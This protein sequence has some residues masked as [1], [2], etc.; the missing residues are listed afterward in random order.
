MEKRSNAPIYIILL[1]I[2]SLSALA[3]YRSQIYIQRLNDVQTIG[4]SENIQK[5]LSDSESELMYLK[6][7]K[8][9]INYFHVGHNDHRCQ[10]IIQ[11][12]KKFAISFTY[13]MPDGEYLLTLHDGIHHSL[14]IPIL[15]FASTKDLVE[16]NKVVLIPDWDAILGYSYTFKHID[17][18]LAKYPWHKK[19]AKVFWRGSPT[20][21]GPE[22]ND[23]N[24]TDR[25]RFLN[26]AKDLPFVDAAFNTYATQMNPEFQAKVAAIHKLKPYVRPEDSII[27]KYLIDIDGNSCSYARMAWILY[28]NSVLFKHMS[29]KVQ[30]YYS[31]MQPYVHYIPIANDFSN[32]QSQFT[33]AESHQIEVEAIALNGRKLAMKVFSRNGILKAAAQGFQR[34]QQ[35]LSKRNI[36]ATREHY[37]T[38]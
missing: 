28:S 14:E 13:D 9:T 34:Y 38:T 11:L 29:N 2:C 35:L 19:Q 4:F 32:L 18:N 10:Q 33:W 31:Q 23:L 30:W 26:Y 8:N 1:F 5:A 22:N 27:Y 16:S 37:A 36:N 20:G 15:S 6:L 7:K 17:Q 25:L 12:V 24:G 3:Y 21:A